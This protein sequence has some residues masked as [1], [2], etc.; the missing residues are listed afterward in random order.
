MNWSLKR[1]LLRNPRHPIIQLHCAGR[2]NSEIIKLLEVAKSTVNY[3][4]KTFKK[5]DTS[6][7]RPRSVRLHT[8][9]SKKMIIAVKERVR[10][11]PKRSARQ[12]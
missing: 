12:M 1:L 6:E 7:D 2:T 8:A 3:V 11:D 4:L 9:R 10:R 5:L